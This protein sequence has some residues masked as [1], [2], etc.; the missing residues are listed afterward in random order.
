MS[1]HRALV[2]GLIGL[3]SLGCILL[4]L[5]VWGVVFDGEFLFKLL[6]TIGIL[7]VLVGFLLVVRADFGEH[8]RLKDENFID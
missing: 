7:V 3:V 8:K 4:I 1:L 6:A 5:S 2:F